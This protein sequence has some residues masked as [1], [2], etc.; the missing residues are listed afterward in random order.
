MQARFF[1]HKH[2]H[3][4]KIHIEACEVRYAV[5]IPT[6]FTA[7][8]LLLPC[9]NQNSY[10]KP[11]PCRNYSYQIPYLRERERKKTA[12][13]PTNYVLVQLHARLDTQNFFFILHSVDFISAVGKNGLHPTKSKQILRNL[14]MKCKRGA[15]EKKGQSESNILVFVRDHIPDL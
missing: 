8:V 1:L 2:K 7:S 4:S 12:S 3:I 13:V 14:T 6:G 9:T 15:M 10:S 5:K 11:Q